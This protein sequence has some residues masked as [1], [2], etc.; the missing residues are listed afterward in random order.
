MLSI[1]SAWVLSSWSST[2]TGI[3]LQIRP[4]IGSHG[5]P[6]I[7]LILSALHLSPSASLVT[8]LHLM[9][10]CSIP[11]MASSVRS[12]VPIHTPCFLAASPLFLLTV[13]IG[14]YNIVSPKN[15][16]GTMH[17]SFRILSYGVRPS[18][19]GAY[20]LT[21]SAAHLVNQT[22]IGKSLFNLHF[23]LLST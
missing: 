1:S 23:V 16:V 21:N 15:T 18:S 8:V 19:P 9:T 2:S 17:S 11:M 3:W 6:L 4:G 13:L 12:I 7:F 14:R 10:P 5:N 22:I 20:L